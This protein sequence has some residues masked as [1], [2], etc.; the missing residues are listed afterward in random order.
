MIVD[1]GSLDSLDEGV[2]FGCRKNDSEWIPLTFYSSLTNQ[3][4]H[5]NVG[6]LR[7]D[8]I[9]TIRGYTIPFIHGNTQNVTLKLCSSEILQDNA[10][11]SFR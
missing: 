7:M 4:D 11:L 3:D 9:L 6:E 2:E 5:I 8:N 1:E 10:S